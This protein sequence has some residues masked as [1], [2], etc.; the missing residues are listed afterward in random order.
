M[1]LLGCKEYKG[2]WANGQH[3]GQALWIGCNGD[4]YN[5]SFKN[6]KRNGRGR[7]EWSDG[8][9]YEV[10][11]KNDQREKG[12]YI[13]KDIASYKYQEPFRQ[14]N[15]PFSDDITATDSDSKQ[16]DEIATNYPIEEGEIGDPKIEH[17][18]INNRRY[19]YDGMWRNGIAEGNGTEISPLEQFGYPHQTIEYVGQY[20]NGT[21]HGYGHAKY[22]WCGGKF[23]L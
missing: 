21:Q 19:S 5:G 15:G 9:F 7:F 10:L 23:W 11:L 13:N 8:A 16:I 20:R 6:G 4:R 12:I 3:H 1:K 22:S 14:D 17:A 2:D 18:S